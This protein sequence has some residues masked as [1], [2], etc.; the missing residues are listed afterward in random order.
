MRFFLD[1][2][3][4]GEVAQIARNLGLDA[5]SVHELGRR[6]LSDDEQF[7]YAIDEEMVMVTRN[8]NDFLALNNEHHANGIPNCGLLI[9]RHRL[10]SEQ[11]A[12]IAH[13]LREWHDEKVNA[14]GS[15]GPHVVGYL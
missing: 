8:R 7:G 11:P 14:P 15:F 9:V 12:R 6:G 1:E 4:S 2:D 5:K 3:I 10:P 13:R